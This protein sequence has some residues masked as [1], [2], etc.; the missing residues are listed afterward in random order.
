M[1]RARFFGYAPRSPDRL[2]QLAVKQAREAAIDIVEASYDL[3][4]SASEWMP[5][6]QKTAA[7]V[8]DL[9]RPFGGASGPAW[10]RQAI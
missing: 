2:E 5:N 6:L 3:E 1:R 4:A 8:F 9:G 7:P 10:T